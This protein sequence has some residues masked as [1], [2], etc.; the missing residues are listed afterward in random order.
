MTI[1]YTICF[2]IILLLGV[3]APVRFIKLTEFWRVGVKREPSQL[4]LNLTRYMSMAAIALIWL[5][6][7]KVF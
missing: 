2:T 3:I 7:F 5:R 6:Y 1:F 4:M